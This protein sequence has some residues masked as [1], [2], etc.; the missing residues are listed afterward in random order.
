[1]GKKKLSTKEFIDRSREVH[2]DKYDYSASVYIN[3]HVKIKI[4]CKEHGEFF[5]LPFSHYGNKQGCPKCSHV[6]TS[7]RCK[8]S[9]EDFIKKAQS[10]HNDRYDYSESVYDGTDTPLTIICKLHG[11]F[12]QTPTSHYT[13]SNCPT[14]ARYSENR[15]V[16]LRE[17]IK[18]SNEIHQNKYD[19]SVS[20]YLSSKEDINIICKKHGV[21]TQRAGHHMNG[22]GCPDCYTES[23]P[24]RLRLTKEEFVERAVNLYGDIYSYEQVEY[25]TGDSRINVKCNKHGI[26]NVRA[27]TFL[28]G[29]GCHSCSRERR[30]L[31]KISYHSVYI[32]IC[33]DI[34]KVGITARDVEDRLYEINKDSGKNFKILKEYPNLTRSQSFNIESQVLKTL[35]DKYRNVVDKF[36]GSTECF[37][38]VDLVW[39]LNYL[40]ELTNKIT[41]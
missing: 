31:Q 36:D 7:L 26:F 17:F 41:D 15:K 9:T 39:L 29:Y 14:C 11:K 20:N 18:R 1:M 19:Y 37:L 12:Q 38:D 6:R 2:G 24:E 27:A 22:S 30:E 21:F 13:G 10:I 34:V 3:A 4:I 33:D 8:F 16:G 25:E 32:L 28:G 40:D 35:S 23:L 5:Q